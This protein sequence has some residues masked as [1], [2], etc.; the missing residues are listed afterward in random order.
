MLIDIHRK[1]GGGEVMEN[2]GWEGWGVLLSQKNNLC[3]QKSSNPPPKKKGGGGITYGKIFTPERN[4][5]L[6]TT[7]K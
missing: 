6:E 4:N 5:C 3:I 7:I 2:I 1:C